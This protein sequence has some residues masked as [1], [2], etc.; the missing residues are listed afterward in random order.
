MGDVTFCSVVDACVVLG[1]DATDGVYIAILVLGVA[2]VAAAA[3]AFRQQAPS[4]ARGPS[5]A[6]GANGWQKRAGD[7]CAAGREVIDLTVVHRPGEP[8]TGLTLQEL[9]TIE[10]KLDLLLARARDVLPRAPTPE[11]SYQMHLVGEHA[12]SLNKAVR[13]ERRVRLSSLDMSSRQL[14]TIVLEFV[15]ERSALDDVLGEISRDIRGKR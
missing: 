7:V 3:F 13:T 9:G 10:T 11:A 12:S 1:L 8:G 2:V 15:S 5:I 4:T 14:D 6:K